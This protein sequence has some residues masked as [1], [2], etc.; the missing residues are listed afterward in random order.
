MYVA[1]TD[2]WMDGFAHG[3][4][5]LAFNMPTYQL[6]TIHRASYAIYRTPGKKV[7]FSETRAVGSTHLP[8]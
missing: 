3:S 5:R 2:L 8:A 6:A 4:L 7:A 1:D